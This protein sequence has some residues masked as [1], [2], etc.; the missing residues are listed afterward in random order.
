L[1]H[2]TILNFK[3]TVSK[4]ADNNN[5]YRNFYSISKKNCWKEWT[6]NY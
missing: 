5:F 3:S 6:F 1:K 2:S 4:D